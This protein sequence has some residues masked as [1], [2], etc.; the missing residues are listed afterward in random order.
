MVLSDKKQ[1]VVDAVALRLPDVEIILQTDG[2]CGSKRIAGGLGYAIVPTADHV[3]E[4]LDT[5][6]L[7]KYVALVISTELGEIPGTSLA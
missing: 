6:P 4:D 5:E 2:I 1:A 7:A 3:F